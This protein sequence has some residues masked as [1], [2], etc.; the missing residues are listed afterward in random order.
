MILNRNLF[1]KK[2]SPFRVH[3]DD[4]NSITAIT[5]KL[6]QLIPSIL[7]QDLVIICI[8]TDR[9]T[10]DSLGP[11]IGTKLSEH[12]LANFHVYG[13]LEHPV[14]AVNLEDTLVE[15]NKKHTR[16]FIIGI[17]AC[18]GRVSSVGKITVGDG[19]IKPGAAV[20]KKLP[21]VGNIHLTG[22]V[23][24]GGMMEYFVLQNTRLHTVMKM[25]TIMASSIDGVDQLLTRRKKHRKSLLETLTPTFFVKE[26]KETHL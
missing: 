20:N 1:P 23:N 24:I 10:G 18:L 11:L 15:I 5:E 14:H 26:R 22:I 2:A 8:G 12:N 9:S 7:T 6:Y 21:E 25:A 19:S 17:D 4:E 13:T 3:M 16:P